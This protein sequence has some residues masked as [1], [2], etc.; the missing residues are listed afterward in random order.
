[1]TLILKREDGRQV[2]TWYYQVAPNYFDTVGIPIVR[3]R[4]ISEG[5][6]R[7]GA[8]VVVV[9]E[10]T[11]RKLWP[12]QEPVGK[13]VMVELPANWGTKSGGWTF[14][15]HQ[16]VGVARD[17]LAL[18]A[19]NAESEPLFMYTPL[20][21]RQPVALLV[22]TA[23]EA[24][25]MQSSV[26]SVSRT[27]DPTVLLRMSF[28][29]DY[30]EVVATAKAVRILAVLAVSL[31]LLALSLAAVGLY[32]VMAY[33]VAQR[34]REIG[35]RVAL[36]AQPRDV[37]RSVFSQGMRL[38]GIGVALGGAGGAAASRVLRSLLFGLSPFDPIAYVSV[39]LFLVAVALLACYL[40]A[41]RATKVDPLTA[42]RHE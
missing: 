41:R 3:G 9:T 4:G 28:L 6:A 20:P 27:I 8:A 36:G 16:V 29:E 23:R 42:L 5:E 7:A 24:K 14:T 11:A 21:P 12:N 10:A 30:F 37:L 1:M 39:S 17:A 34:T 18:M 25:E 40:P 19:P 2:I 13:N 32:G 22:R 15:S 26:R 35:I 31:G 38:V 33:S